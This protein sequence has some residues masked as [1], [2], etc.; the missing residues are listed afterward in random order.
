MMHSD[1]KKSTNKLV[2]AHC[3]EKSLTHKHPPNTMITYYSD[4]IIM[5]ELIY[6]MYNIYSLPFP[7]Q[8]AGL[9]K[10]HEQ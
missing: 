5:N 9:G 2:I 10:S 4:C 8:S 3:P 7:F 1:L 6:S